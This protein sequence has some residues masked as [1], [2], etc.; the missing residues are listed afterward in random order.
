MAHRLG[1]GTGQA[2]VDFTASA[3][4]V[5]APALALVASNGTVLAWGDGCRRL[6]GYRAE[7]VVG[8]SVERLTQ[9][10]VDALSW[11][12]APGAVGNRGSRQSAGAVVEARHQDGRVLPLTV[13]IVAAGGTDGEDCWF[14]AVTGAAG[15]AEAGD[16]EEG[17]L[18]R[19]PLAV[20]VW[21]SDMRLMWL[22]RASKE[23]MGLPTEGNPG[24]SVLRVLRG[25]DRTSVGPVLRG[26]L[27]SGQPVGN[28]VVRWVSPEDGRELVFSSSLFPLAPRD[29][30]LPGMCSVSLDIT[31]SW[32]RERLALLSRAAQRIGTTL[33]VLTTAQELAD[34][35]VPALADYVAVDLAEAVP[36]GEEP[37]ERMHEGE[38]GI[39][40]FRRAGMASIHD[41]VPEAPYKVGEVVYVALGSP[42][43]AALREGRS[44]LNPILESGP[45]TW[46]ARDPVRRRRVRE[47]GMHSL[48]TIPLKARGTILGL[49]SFARNENV[50]P[51]SRNDLLLAEEL[52]VQASLS[53]DN[54]RRYTRERTAALTLQR[55]LL[56]EHLSGGAAVDL[57]SRYL[58]S[59]RYEGVGGDLMDAIEL[60]GGRIALVIGDVVGHGIHAAA[61]M[62]RLRTA[63]HTLAVLDQPPPNCSTTSTRSP[64]NSHGGTPGRPPA[65]RR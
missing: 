9:G 45:G 22:N 55:S 29:G 38:L 64:S 25:F 42:Y 12:A 61:S 59:A 53:L 34:M 47:T 18:D 35:A 23:L 5:A 14:V 31:R 33:D 8:R 62:G 63:V 58:P 21:D 46:L 15:G 19:S 50:V 24:E 7:E 1:A 10:P 11:S 57:A 27:E 13:E 51:F 30:T 3:S 40:V 2:S 44:Y 60:P 41:G 52:A 37:L 49:V 32:E 54:A 39:P 20:A 48:M 26:V 28:H 16:G 17:L 56:S 4:D 6:L 65:I 43:L 36:L